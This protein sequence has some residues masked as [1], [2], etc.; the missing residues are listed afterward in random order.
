MKT[1]LIYLALGAT[2]LASPV[3]A[4]DAVLGI[5][6][7]ESTS[8]EY[9][10]DVN[11]ALR[12]GA[13]ATSM[14]VF[15]DEADKGGEYVADPDW[16][17][18]ANSYYP[19]KN[20]GLILSL[21]VI[22]TV[23][24]R[25]PKDLQRLDWDDPEVIARFESYV[26]AILAR[27]SDTN[28]VAISIGNEIDGHLDRDK[29]WRAYET[30]FIAAKDLVHRL[31]PGVPVGFTMTWQGMQGGTGANVNAHTDAMFI[32][33]Y[34]LDGGFHVLPP[35]DIAAQLD[36]MISVASGKPVF[37]TETGY[38]SGG[39]GSSEALQL[40]Y[41]QQLFAAWQSRKAAIPVVN[42]VWLHEISEE[43]TNG[44]GGY[45]GLKDSCFLDYLGTL[46]LRSADGVNKLA[47]DWLV[48]R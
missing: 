3:W 34:P 10:D 31:R 33:Y 43:S 23:T 28:L 38:P 15:W 25:R 24:D 39:C 2:V 17:A 27:L 7:T 14:T 32:N 5:A 47:F 18:I 35:T 22:D 13:D 30:F 48:N 11:A 21:P 1:I 42:L 45:Y 36:A 9:D 16:P 29:D 41:F 20:L 6:I 37:L 44:Y 19:S 40:E 8:G 12:A 46:G 26:T 4:K